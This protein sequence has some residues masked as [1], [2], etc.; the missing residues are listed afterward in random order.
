MTIKFYRTT[1]EY[2][3][4]SNFSR[5]PVRFGVDVF[6]TSEHFFQQA[7]FST[8]DKEWAA[9]IIAAKTPSQCATMGRDRSHPLR[10]D[11]EIIKDDVMR[12]ALVAKFTQNKDCKEKLLSTG[13]QYLIEDTTDDY[14][15]GTGI[16]GTGKNKLGLLLM[17]V[18]LALHTDTI[19]QYLD[20]ITK[21]LSATSVVQNPV[22]TP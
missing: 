20:W 6:M 14:Y 18:R 22:E 8:T 4:F 10:S 11:W 21:R 3:C 15:W 9:Q 1:E 16:T 17:E 7:K 13:D 2:G 19:N 12:T 5:H